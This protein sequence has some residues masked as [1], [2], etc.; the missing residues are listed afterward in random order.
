MIKKLLIFVIVSLF[1]ISPE[2]RADGK[3]PVFKNTRAQEGIGNT[4][5]E[6]GKI[7]TLTF[8]DDTTQTTAAAG[9]GG[10]VTAGANLG[11]NFLI[12]GDGAVKGV[13]N[14]G[15]SI[16]DSDAMTGVTLDSETNS[17]MSDGE[18][19][20]AYNNSGAGLVKGN[21]VYIS[22]ENVGADL[23]EISKADAS[24]TSTMSCIGVVSETI[25]NGA[26]GLVQVSGK[27]LGLNTSTLSINDSLYVS[28]TAGA[29]TAT[30]PTGTALIQKM[31]VVSKIHAS[32]GTIE[33]MGAY[34]TNDIPNIASANFWLGNG[35][36]V[37][38]AVTMSGDINM[39]N[40]GAATIQA[41]AVDD[42]HIDWGTGANQ[43]A[44]TDIPMAIISGATYSTVQDL[45]NIFHS[46]GWVSGGGITDD[47]DGTITVAAG[48]GFI[49]ATDTAVA[50]ILFM[51]WAAE[52][53]ANV[54]LA[55]ND[56]SWVYVEY[57]TGSPQVVATTTERTDFNTNVLLAVIQRSGTTLHINNPQKHVVGDHAN[58]MIRRLKET[59]KFAR[60]SGAVISATGTRN[61]AITTGDF[62]EGLGEFTLA[63]FDSSGADSFSY[64]YR[65]VSDSGWNE[66][67]TQSPIHQTNYDDNSGSLATLSN[68]KYG[69]HWCYIE[70]DDHAHVVY[71][72]G[73][74]TLAQAEDASPPAGVPEPIE[75]NGILVGKIIIKE[76]AAAFTQIES[77]FGTAFTPSVAVDHGAL[78]GLTDVADHAY[79]LLV[80][81]TRALAGAW[82][83]GSQATTNVNIDSGTING[84]TDLAVADGGTG[85]SALTNLIT[86][87]TH[88]TGNY[89]TGNA[90]A[91]DALVS[92][93]AEITDNEATNEENP[94][95]FVAGA[96]P[97]GGDLPLETDGDFTYNPSTGALSITA[98][99]T[100]T[101][102]TIQF[103]AS[104]G[105][106]TIASVNGTN[107]ETWT[108]DLE[109][110][111][112]VVTH[113]G[114]G[115]THDFSSLTGFDVPANSIDDTE[116][117]WG[118]GANQVSIADLAGDQ[119]SGALLWNL[120]GATNFEIPNGATYSP[121]TVVGQIGLDT[122]ITSH[123]GMLRYYVGAVEMIIPAIP[124]AD[125]TTTDGHVIDYNAAGTKFTMD[126]PAA[127]G[128]TNSLEVV[129]T[130]IATTEIPIGTA[131]DTVVYAALSG[132]VTMDNA[133]AV[134]IANDAVETAMIN[135]DA[136][137][138][139]GIDADGAFTSLTGAWATTGL[140]SGGVVTKSTAA[141]Y[142]VGTTNAAESYSGVIYVTS[143]A[144][145]TMP[146]VGAGMSFAIITI[147]A[148][149]VSVDTN[150]SD[151]MY[152]DGTA[153]DDGDKATNTSTTGD[154]IVCIY[155]SANGWYCSSGSP[156]GDLWTD[157]G[158]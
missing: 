26:S 118:T 158:P 9:G 136:V 152:L 63:A 20:E 2:I 94:I 83:M 23:P 49:R 78:V 41:N 121:G 132:D 112:N 87:T 155:E 40:T 33:I 7:D 51:D 80:D 68:N 90:E 111:N 92:I 135:T 127:G 129:C 149:A 32:L 140:S 77:A 73:D 71:G 95:V 18:H 157:G 97:D 5:N 14:T 13:Q 141:S 46:A 36:G 122:T 47:A 55:D 91:G 44:A 58:S 75:A 11:D 123:N 6:D 24:D 150:A 84:I 131:A 138:M 38:T 34:R 69:V 43:V 37:P 8:S 156:D 28:E 137:T 151:R 100:G 17:V 42:T 125:L 126:A 21:L 15:I 120:G 105:I 142:T 148:T 56:I 109:T 54:N 79:A 130:A 22:G 93:A 104:T 29:S 134:T 153:L 81:G 96:D 72:Q 45:Q 39:D 147:G 19:R 124:A 85:A 4:F 12:R 89:S 62:W 61:W 59:M 110:V 106:L 133:G 57:N 1:L 108:I 10:D 103:S 146:A 107:N 64:W 60:V 144:T 70:T 65:Q 113:G 128:E 35:S 66:V 119:I 52:S 25:A 116:I 98:L 115:V 102:Q 145:I 50:E 16:D 53:G 82:D 48:T 114:T 139:D 31:A 27:M 101:A 86:L 76:S 74:Y 143:A 30:K 67:A 154:T 99:L 117:D 88:T 3:T